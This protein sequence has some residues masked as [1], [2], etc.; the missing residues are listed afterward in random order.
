MITARETGAIEIR[1][2]NRVLRDGEVIAT[3]YHRHVLMPGDDLT[4]QDPRVQAIAGANWTPEQCK[5]VTAK[6]VEI[7]KAETAERNAALAEAEAAKAAAE[8]ARAEVE[9]ISTAPVAEVPN[10]P[11]A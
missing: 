5:A 8:M 7:A 4:G 10:E 11:Q 1:T 9:A 2:S 6:I 3:T